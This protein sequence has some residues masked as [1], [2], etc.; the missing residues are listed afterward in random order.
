MRKETNE[1]FPKRGENLALMKDVTHTHT[2][3]C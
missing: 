1:H 3:V 2:K